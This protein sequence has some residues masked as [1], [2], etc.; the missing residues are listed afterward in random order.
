[1][2]IVQIIQLILVLLNEVMKAINAQQETIE[3]EKLGSRHRK[4]LDDLTDYIDRQKRN[5]Q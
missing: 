1:M 3:I 4:A 5:A 2:P